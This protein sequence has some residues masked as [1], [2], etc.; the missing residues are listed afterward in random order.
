MNELL[1]GLTAEAARALTDEVKSDAATLWSKLLELYEGGAHTALGYSSWGAYYKVEF[2]GS[3]T[4]GYELLD[5]GRVDRLVSQSGIP[6]ST[7]RSEGVA[8][9]LVPVLREDPERV[10]EV[11]AEVVEEHGPEPTAVQVRD[12]VQMTSPKEQVAVRVK[13]PTCGHMVK[14]EDFKRGV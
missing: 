11:W 13:C 6:D 12:H 2:G 3:R 10:E 1:T 4:R 14:P 8:N 5:A 7:P 9:E